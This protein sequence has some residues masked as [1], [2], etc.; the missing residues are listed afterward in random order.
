MTR[1]GSTKLQLASS[2]INSRFAVE[3]ERREMLEREL[4]HY[5]EQVCRVC[6]CVC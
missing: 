4:E 1:G 6:E 5:R 3:K 2:L